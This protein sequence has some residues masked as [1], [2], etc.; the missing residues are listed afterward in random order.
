MC[1]LGNVSF[2]SRC[3]RASVQSVGFEE[4]NESGRGYQASEEF[5]ETARRERLDATR[6]SGARSPSRHRLYR[7]IGQP[8]I[9]LPLSLSSSSQPL[10]A[11][12]CP[13]QLQHALP[14]R[15]PRLNAP[16]CC[17][18]ARKHLRL[19]HLVRHSRPRQPFPPCCTFLTP[20][21]FQRH[22]RR[23]R[24]CH[25][26]SDSTPTSAK[27]C[28]LLILVGSRRYVGAASVFTDITSEAGS[29]YTD[30]TSVSRAL[31]RSRSGA[32]D[33]PPRPWSRELT[34]LDAGR[35]I[36]LYCSHVG[37]RRRADHN[38]IWSARYF[39]SWGGAVL[40]LRFIQTPSEPSVLQRQG[41]FPSTPWVSD[42]ILP[43]QQL[44]NV[45]LLETVTS[46]ADG[47]LT[48]LTSDVVG[49]YSTATSGSLPSSTP[50]SYYPG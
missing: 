15:P 43:S 20:F 7:Y 40:T 4:K 28:C 30:V 33:V 21:A 48:T 5:A 34:R 17:S 24:D 19:D 10:L 45:F 47:A 46:N 3:D 2:C 32:P 1:E 12:F 9:A 23:C 16:P 8:T 22:W 11:H 39:R 14:P 42:L 18:F 37:G 44:S 27:C 31:S 35:G 6:F 41:L 50:P 36:G 29:V 38:H 13:L 49:A 25:L 26:R